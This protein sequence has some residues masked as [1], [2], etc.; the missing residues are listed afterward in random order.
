MGFIYSNKNIGYHHF[1]PLNEMMGFARGQL[2]AETG[3]NLFVY[4]EPISK[5][6]RQLFFSP[7]FY[8]SFHKIFT[9]KDTFFFILI[10]LAVVTAPL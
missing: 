10:M 9:K 3:L 2:T 6:R 5:S 8:L 4:L 7:L 1:Y